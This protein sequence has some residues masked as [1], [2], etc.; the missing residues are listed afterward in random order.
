MSRKLKERINLALNG[1]IRLFKKNL[2]IDLNP[3]VFK[4]APKIRYF[5]L[6][7]KWKPANTINTTLTPRAKYLTREI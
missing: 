1:K 2:L 6:F 5:P 7:K 4:T 3:L